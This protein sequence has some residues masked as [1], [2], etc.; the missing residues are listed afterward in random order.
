V[1]GT[2]DRR[3]VVTYLVQNHQVSITRACRTSGFSKSQYYYQS[4]K[5]DSEVVDKLNALVENKPNRGFP[6]FFHRIRNEGYVWNHKKVKRV[7][8]LMNL[9]KRRKHKR[10]LPARFREPLA[11]PNSINGTWSIDF[12]HD[13][14]MNGRKVRI[15][16]IIDD[17]NREALTINADY[18]Q[19]GRTVVSALEDLK[20]WRGRPIEIRCDNGPEFL[21]NHF[22]D[23]CQT[24]GIHIKYI[25][26]GKPTQ[27][28]YIERFN[29]SY[30]EDVLDAYMFES[31]RHLRELS[32]EWQDEY[33]E[34]HPHQSLNNLSPNK[35][36][37]INT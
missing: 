27:N 18:S 29:R 10:R 23:Y 34:F 3:T 22:V 2:G 12:M 32:S 36:L 14:L 16:N 13:T 24:Q 11:Q 20:Y 26:P 21:S 15:L 8:K 31:L 1:V 33:N 6:Y 25:Q 7:Y 17:F 9:N 19:S 37:E 4:K 35:Y 5:D 30:R 28:A